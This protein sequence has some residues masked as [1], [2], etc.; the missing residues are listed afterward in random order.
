M[1]QQPCMKSSQARPKNKVLVKVVVRN[2][3]IEKS[4]LRVQRGPSFIG[5]Y[6]TLPVHKED[7]PGVCA[8]T[9][10]DSAVHGA[11]PAVWRGA[12][13]LGFMIKPMRPSWSLLETSRWRPSRLGEGGS[14][15]R[16]VCYF[17]SLC[18]SY[19]YLFLFPLYSNLS[20]H[21]FIHSTP[22]ECSV[23]HEE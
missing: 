13:H 20:F 14:F 4:N 21:S 2:K 5:I 22:R 7:C 11:T 1:Q 16:W 15:R 18:I 8:R 6:S 9:P 19:S 23:I 10:S 17:L 3:S 12:K